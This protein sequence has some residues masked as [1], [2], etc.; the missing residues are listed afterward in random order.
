MVLLPIKI[1]NNLNKRRKKLMIDKL[2]PK[3]FKSKCEA[4]RKRDIVKTKVK[5][6]KAVKTMMIVTNKKVMNSQ[7][8]KKQ[9][10]LK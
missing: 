8:P 4:K 2:T 7:T 1:R 6:M 3:K 5:T 10:K 9:K